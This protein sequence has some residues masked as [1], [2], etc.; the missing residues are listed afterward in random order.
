MK[1]V[2]VYSDPVY[3]AT[4]RIGLE[5]ARNLLGKVIDKWNE[6]DIGPVVDLQALIRNCEQE[7]STAI[8][9]NVEV[10][11]QAGKYQISKDIWIK[12]LNIP[13][14]NMLYIACR[15]CR[16]QPYCQNIGL[17]QIVDGKVE[18]VEG[19]A[20]ALIDAQSIYS[21][22]PVKIRFAEDMKIFVDLFNSLNVRSGGELFD[23]AS[24]ISNRFFF[25]RFG[26]EGED[27]RGS[28]G[29]LK[30]II[31]YWRKFLQ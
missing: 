4:V 26:F 11:V 13:V 31:D 16:K 22:D 15:E 1:K 19:E 9:R 24:P 10:P 7:Y 27:G 18:M 8:N 17:W 6:L 14:P 12:T 23:S 2:K 29:S 25:G 28:N 5:K 20:E 3:E 30:I 21:D